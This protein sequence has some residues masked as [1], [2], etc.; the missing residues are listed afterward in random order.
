MKLYAFLL[1]LSFFLPSLG[2]VFAEQAVQPVV[3]QDNPTVLWNEAVG[4]YQDGRFDEALAG[5]EKLR[6]TGYT[7]PDLFYNLGNCYYQKGERGEAI[8]MYEKCLKQNPRHKDARKNRAIARATMA[9]PDQGGFFLFKPFIAVAHWFTAGEW[10]G[11]AMVFSFL[12]L[13]PAVA[14]LFLTA[15]RRFYGWAAWIFL[16]ITA[17]TYSFA[18]PRY[19]EE[20]RSQYAIVTEANVIIQSAPGGKGE[21]Y[22]EAPEGTRIEVK[23]APLQNWARVKHPESGRVGYLPERTF[24][25]I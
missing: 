1:T 20:A 23:P 22:V 17:L 25:E 24:R 21:D 13:L 11:A 15:G 10:L 19:W 2:G 4:H 16:G 7:H 6:Q 3:P 14:W 5:F 9:E 18:L 8:W 12:T